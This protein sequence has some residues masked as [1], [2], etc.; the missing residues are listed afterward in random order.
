M[1]V[2]R[3]TSGKNIAKSVEQNLSGEV[4]I[5]TASQQIVRILW[6]LISSPPL[7]KPANCPSPELDKSNKGYHSIC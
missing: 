2:Y 5:A 4:V 7:Q 6:K 1:K 3:G